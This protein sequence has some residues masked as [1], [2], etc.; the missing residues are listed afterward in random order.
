MGN[1]ATTDDPVTDGKVDVGEVGDHLNPA[2]S[3]T[4]SA[5]SY[6]VLARKYRPKTFDA[7]VGQDSLVRTIT[8][9]ITSGRLAQAYMLTGVRGVG[10]TTT[11][12]LIARALNCVGIDGKGGA[13]PSPCGE[14]EHCRSIIRD[15]HVDVL[16]MDAAS[17]TGVEDIRELLES[18]R[19]RP[20]TAR[21]KIYIVDEVHM[22]STHAFNALLKT[23][24]EP[25]E[26]VMFIFATTEIRK[27]PITVLSRCQRFDLR[28]ITVTDLISL[29]KGIVKKEQI[30][31]DDD[32]LGLVARAADGSAR[33]GLS[34]LDQAISEASGQGGQ[35]VTNGQVRD[36]LGLADRARVL[37]L[38]EAVMQGKAKEALAILSD[39]HRSGAD[40]LAVLQ[41]L[42]E[43]CHVVTR[44]KVSPEAVS[45]LMLA[46]AERTRGAA[47]AEVLSM[48]ILTRCW[49]M[50]LKGLGE[51]HHAP[52]PLQAVEMV[53]VRLTYAADLPTPS[54]ALR[55]LKKDSIDEKPG[56]TL[57]SQPPIGSEAAL[58]GLKSLVQTQAIPQ[59]QSDPQSAPSTE[60]KSLD[61]PQSFSEV[62]VLFEQRREIQLASHLR[63]GV[64]LVR[65]EPGRI[66]VQLTKGIPKGLVGRVGK[67]LS[68]WTGKRWVIS[69]SNQNGETTLHEQ[70][71]AAITADPLVRSLLDAF[72][73]AAIQDVGSA[74]E[75]DI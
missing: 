60:A 27:V 73:D 67:L 57:V 5:D 42:L 17:R 66:E 28:R 3:K 71:M 21:F 34:I 32:A 72:P 20:V 36:M 52:H 30:E 38:F 55:A 53:I 10:K 15:G 24:E 11:A 70:T 45:E 64:R 44:L 49:Q 50:L 4:V 59:L 22:L 54:E 9:A 47:M 63:R 8:N 37:D 18:V 41:D 31:V 46:E 62:V 68:Q 69:V 43:V 33:D 12:R 61:S 48:P 29:F 39:Q 74:P 51:A 25:P 2:S 13:T 1:G 65:F 35:V 19:Y 40:P 7:L 14:C 6:Q 58:T 23:L 26:H 16:E 75:E 56:K